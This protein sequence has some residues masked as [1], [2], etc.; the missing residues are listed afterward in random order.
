MN[1]EP[2]TE[3]SSPGEDFGDTGASS[4]MVRFFMNV[5]RKQR[6]KAKDIIIAVD[7]NT[8]LSSQGNSAK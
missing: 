3:S 8:G 6:I 7:Q 4:G 5:G 1:K 2:Q